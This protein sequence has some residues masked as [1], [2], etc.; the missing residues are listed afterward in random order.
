[1]GFFCGDDIVANFLL[2]RFQS[3]RSGLTQALVELGCQIPKHNR[4]NTFHHINLDQQAR[5]VVVAILIC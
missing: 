5:R 2:P 4:A 1:M 3:N